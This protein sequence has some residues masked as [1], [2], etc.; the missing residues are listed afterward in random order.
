[1]PNIS[2]VPL[3]FYRRFRP[4]AYPPSKPSG[5][6]DQDSAP[7]DRQ[8]R[9]QTQIGKTGKNGPDPRHRRCSTCPQHRPRHRRTSPTDQIA[10][11]IS[12]NRTSVLLAPRRQTKG[13]KRRRPVR[14]NAGA[15]KCGV[16]DRKS[17]ATDGISKSPLVSALCK[18][19]S[20]WE[21]LVC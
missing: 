5:K 16:H 10:H 17:R 20:W 7:Q 11:S 8:P 1:M 14:L 4:S 6:C 21:L 13:E 3:V 15:T 19:E 2:C 12:S 18:L 9:A